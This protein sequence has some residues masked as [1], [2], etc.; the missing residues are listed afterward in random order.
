MFL[1]MADVFIAGVAFKALFHHDGRFVRSAGLFAF[2]K[3]QG[4]SHLILHLELTDA[5]NRWAGPAHTR[6]SWALREGMNELLAC[7]ASSP[8]SVEGTSRTEP[9]VWH[10][11]AE[12]WLQG[13]LWPDWDENEV[14]R[15]EQ[16][17]QA[18]CS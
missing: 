8:A 10:P 1:V 9:V 6:W 4:R 14:T 13:E 7:P 15:L 11:E 5:I 3:R 2:A 12:V 18:L 16:R 17:L